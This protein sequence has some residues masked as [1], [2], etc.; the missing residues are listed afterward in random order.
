ML[1]GDIKGTLRGY[2]FSKGSF[3]TVNDTFPFIQF[4]LFG[5]FLQTFLNHSFRICHKL[6][7]W[8]SMPW[9]KKNTQKSKFHV[10]F[11][12]FQ[13]KEWSLT[14]S[15]SETK[16]NDIYLPGDIGRCGDTHPPLSFM[17]LLTGYTK[18]PYHFSGIYSSPIPTPK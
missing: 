9:C 10:I 17:Y 15:S 3:Y 14:T 7:V 13:L 8:K 4:V 11:H 2:L 6:S 1:V 16:G 12:I 18:T 5:F